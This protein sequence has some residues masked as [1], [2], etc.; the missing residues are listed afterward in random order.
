MKK[1]DDSP[2][3]ADDVPPLSK[4]A[5]KPR[6]STTNVSRDDDDG[7]ASAPPQSQSSS[8]TTTAAAKKQQHQVTEVPK[9]RFVSIAKKSAGYSSAAAG[10]WVEGKSAQELAA[11]YQEPDIVASD[12]SSSSVKKGQVVVGKLNL[13]ERQVEMGLGAGGGVE[14]KEEVDGVKEEQVI[15]EEQ[16]NEAEEEKE[17]EEEVQPTPTVQEE[18]EEVK[19]SVMKESVD[20][21]EENDLEAAVPPVT[22][23]KTDVPP[24]TQNKKLF[25][26]MR[27]GVLYCSDSGEVVATVNPVDKKE[28]DTSKEED[29]SDG[30]RK[31]STKNRILSV[32][33]L[34]LL[35]VVAAL[36]AVFATKPSNDDTSSGLRGEN[37]KNEEGT[38]AAGA[39][40]TATAGPSETP[41]WDAPTASPKSPSTA[42]FNEPTLKPTQATAVQR[43]IVG[44]SLAE[45]T[46][47]EE[48]LIRQQLLCLEMGLMVLLN[49]PTST[50]GILSHSSMTTFSLLRPMEVNQMLVFIFTSKII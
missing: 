36:G 34:L 1:A 45:D 49:L 44:S 42:F 31:C 37:Q 33:L 8:T 9:F 41:R 17:E 16:E 20:Q 2:S 32:L 21:S 5:A 38:A 26:D 10:R 48:A 27:Q 39:N 25:Y 14:K 4:E 22:P 11:Q 24:V 23:N 6:Q 18:E 30:R 43:C 46:C 19:E 7:A 28:E 15:E 47:V 3:A 12:P 29:A 40:T 13:A 50:L 35:A